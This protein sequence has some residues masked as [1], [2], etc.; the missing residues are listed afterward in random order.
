MSTS[1]EQDQI[2]WMT[3]LRAPGI[4]GV[5]ARSL[6][7]RHGD[8]VKA[9]ARARRDSD[10]PASAKAWLDAPDTAVIERDLAWLAEPDH[11]LVAWTSEDYPSLLRDISGAPAALFVVG[12]PS[13]LWLPQIAIVGSRKA[14][15][16]GVINARAFAKALVQAG[17]AVTSGLAEGIDGAAHAAA[18]DA[19]GATLAVLG[20]GPDIV[21]PRQHQ[22]LAERIVEKGA[23][24][25]EFPPG[26][27]GRPENFPRRNRIIAGLSLGTLVIEADLKSGSLITARLASEQGR[28][29]FALPGSIHSP[30]SRGCHKLIREGAKLVETS[31]EVLEEVHGISSALAA[32]LRER[33]SIDTKMPV[34]ERFAASNHS[35]DPDYARL[36]QALDHAPLALDELA[37]RSGLP[38]SSLSSMLLMLE[39]DGVVRADAGRYAR[40][41]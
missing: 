35:N 32:R 33:L 39:L 2:A 9:V 1:S 40:A 26:T 29:V 27:Q 20:T 23:L 16:G 25:S 4:G 7:A 41:N 31:D 11:H 6:L 8:I 34:V 17:I 14:S 19:G 10:V 12:D 21:Y 38:T 37:A 3:L 13:R 5:T 22:K 36:L 30:L 24:I 28:E 15:A 18:V